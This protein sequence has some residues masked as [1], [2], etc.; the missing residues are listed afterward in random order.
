MPKTVPVPPVYRP[1]AVAPV[2]AKP[3]GVASAKPLPKLP[4]VFKPVRPGGPVQAR[5]ASVVQRAERLPKAVA[6][7]SLASAY[8]VEELQKAAEETGND[9]G[10]SGHLS[11]KPGDGM[12]SATTKAAKEIGD[13]ARENKV[14][15]KTE[16]KK[17][18][19]R[20]E[21]AKSPLWKAL[22]KGKELM[23]GALAA[24][25]SRGHSKSD[26]LEAAYVVYD[27]Y[28][29]AKST[30]GGLSGGDVGKCTEY[31]Y[32]MVKEYDDAE[33]LDFDEYL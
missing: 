12:N 15:E 16:R 20:E 19:V 31:W 33:V 6:Y 21:S 13:R 10:Y 17:A 5:M 9:T 28:L 11:G 1:N 30:P 22:N 4:P 23:R 14:K 27:Q 8:T 24:A 26:N 2:Q 25:V 3:A 29:T 32:A 7:T 18:P